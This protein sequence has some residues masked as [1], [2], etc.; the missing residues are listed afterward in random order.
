MDIPSPGG[1][2][3]SSPPAGHL[4]TVLVRS[5]PTR[6][7]SPVSREMCGGAGSELLLQW[8][9]YPASATVELMDVYKPPCR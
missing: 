4:G 6:G 5:F 1:Q 3:V 7:A 8:E 9:F 2:K